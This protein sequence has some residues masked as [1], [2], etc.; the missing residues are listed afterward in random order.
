MKRSIFTGMLGLGLAVAMQPVSA[1]GW[2]G[3]ISATNVYAQGDQATGDILIQSVNGS[4]ELVPFMATAT[5]QYSVSVAVAGSSHVPAGTFT[6]GFGGP[7]AGAGNPPGNGGGPPIVIL[8]DD[9]GRL[10]FSTADVVDASVPD[11]WGMR[12]LTGLGVCAALSA[13][14]HATAVYACSGPGGGLA[15]FSMSEC[16]ASL[17]YRCMNSLPPPLPSQPPLTQYSFPF[18]PFSIWD[19]AGRLHL[20][21][22]GY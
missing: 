17:Q 14:Q 1:Q 6:L 15:A 10:D 22:M 21:W 19:E 5:G 3:T 16:G 11:G 20:F 2:H 4:T 8:G 18:G 7:G 12:I 9:S 13:L